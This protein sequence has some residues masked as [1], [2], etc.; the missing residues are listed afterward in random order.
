MRISG[1]GEARAH[2]Y[3]QKF[4]QAIAEYMAQHPQG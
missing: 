4:L 3:G 2:R 1:V